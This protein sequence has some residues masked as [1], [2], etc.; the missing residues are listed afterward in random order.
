ASVLIALIKNSGIAGAFAVADLTGVAERINNT[1]AQPIAVFL[2]AAV[3]YVILAL[4]TGW[5]SG[6]LERR[7]A[8]KR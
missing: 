3:A 5:A 8:I 4:P 2:G 6:V 7:V 1:T